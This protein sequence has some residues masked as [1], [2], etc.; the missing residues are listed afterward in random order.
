MKDRSYYRL[1]TNEALIDEGKYNPS[2]ELCIVLA[3]RLEQ[4]EWG[5][6]EAAHLR[7]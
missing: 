5:V 2:I 7:N 1:E 3:E 6:R 4:A